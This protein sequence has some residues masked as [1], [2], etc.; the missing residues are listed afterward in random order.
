MISEMFPERRGC[1]NGGVWLT[2]RSPPPLGTLKFIKE[3]IEARDLSLNARSIE[4]INIDNL[5]QSPG[6]CSRFPR[7]MR[8]T[9]L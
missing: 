1:L 9:A 4:E 3:S 8:R 7:A 5:L 2:R 6:Y